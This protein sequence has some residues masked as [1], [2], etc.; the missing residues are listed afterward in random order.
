MITCSRRERSVSNDIQE[1]LPH[2]TMHL[3]V[4]WAGLKPPV[5]S[6]LLVNNGIAMKQIEVTAC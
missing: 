1:L 6:L 4:L 3:I 5:V 2:I